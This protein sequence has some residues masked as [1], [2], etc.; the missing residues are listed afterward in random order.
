MGKAN[1]KDA[2][3]REIRITHIV[4]K[5]ISDILHYIGSVNHQ[6]LNAEKV[7]KRII[8]TITRIELNPDAFGECPEIPNIIPNV[9]PGNMLVMANCVSNKAHGNH[10]FRRDP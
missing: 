6:P 4:D 8:S 9:S 7:R 10:Y 3:T 5:N 1:R 2:E